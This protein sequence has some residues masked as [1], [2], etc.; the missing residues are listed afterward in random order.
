LSEPIPS[1]YLAMHLTF[2]AVQAALVTVIVAIVY[3][4]VMRSRRSQAAFDAAALQRAATGRRVAAAR[5]ATLQAQIDPAL[6]FSTLELA[7][8][9]YERDPEAAERTLAELI[10]FLRTALPK[11]GEEGSTLERELHLARAY[12]GI[13]G[14][15][16]GSRLDA[17]FEIPRELDGA[18]FPAMVLVP[19]V[20]HAVQH[21]LEPLT[22]GG[23]VEI[24]AAK[25]ADD[26]EVIVAYSGTDDRNT[27]WL[28]PLHER[29][30]GLY[31]DGARL[32]VTTAAHG[33]VVT[34][35]V[36]YETAPAE[37]PAVPAA[38]TAAPLQ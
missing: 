14:A 29:L 30:D 3:S 1:P 27:T 13:V 33:P 10:D 16:M 36:P 15:R 4:S 9:L 7:E 31:G 34:V 6:L 23:K 32:S 25:K 24:R 21:G 28:D 12:L 18:S 35:E 5:L 26:L 17:R 37:P 11:V 20:E 38:T 22:H 2:T 8:T 19:L